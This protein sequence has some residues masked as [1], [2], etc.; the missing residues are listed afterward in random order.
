MIEKAFKIMEILLLM[1]MLGALE[2]HIVK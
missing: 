1:I 2:C